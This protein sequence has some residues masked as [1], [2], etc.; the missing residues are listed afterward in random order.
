MHMGGRH[1][2]VDKVP[3]FRPSLLMPTAATLSRG[4][5]HVRFCPDPGLA[6]A[7]HGLYRDSPTVL[8]RV[9]RGSFRVCRP[10]IGALGLGEVWNGSPISP[11]VAFC[12]RH[13]KRRGAPH[14]FTY[15]ANVWTLH[16][17]SRSRLKVR[18][19]SATLSL[20]RLKNSDHD[21]DAFQ[22]RPN[23]HVATYAPSTYLGHQPH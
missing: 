1:T 23:P 18:S 13:H 11:R 9:H 16:A 2:F 12:L 22:C 20:Y 7:P 14:T 21:L 5:S 8:Y 3:G 6:G 19:S 4:K 10:T 15:S 17:P